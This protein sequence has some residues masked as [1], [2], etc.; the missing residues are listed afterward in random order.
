MLEIPGTSGFIPAM[1]QVVQNVQFT[2]NSTSAIGCY[3]FH[4]P[5]SGVIQSVGISTLDCVGTLPITGGFYPLN[6]TTMTPILTSPK[7]PGG[8]GSIAAS[9]YTTLWIPVN[10]GTGVTVARGDLVSY[11]ISMA[12]PSGA[13]N[14]D[15]ANNYMI[16]TTTYKHAWPYAMSSGNGG[17]SWTVHTEAPAITLQYSDGIVCPVGASTPVLYST[18]NLS[19]STNPRI[20]GNRFTLPYDCDVS[21]VWILANLPNNP[22]NVVLFGTDGVTRL[23]QTRVYSFAGGQAQG[24]YVVQFPVAVPIRRGLTY[25]VAIEPLSSSNGN[26]YK[27]TQTACPGY[28]ALSDGNL[29]PFFRYTFASSA[30]TSEA[31]WS[32]TT[33]TYFKMGIYLSN[34]HPLLYG[35]SAGFNGGFI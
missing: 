6:T 11:V 14:I 15:I 21:G 32:N 31:S 1:G 26:V 3:L 23:A 29:Y 30:P 7:Y 19:T 33:D 17:T 22:C 8:T 2:M 10:E 4:I 28:P 34:I 27:M 20:V 9:P 5:K 12:T 25:R 16:T 13:Y 24:V 18:A 35:K